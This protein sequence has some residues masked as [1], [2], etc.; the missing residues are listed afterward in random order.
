MFAKLQGLT[1]NLPPMPAAPAVPNL[2]I[3]N[4]LRNSVQ[5]GRSVLLPLSLARALLL[6]ASP[7][8]SRTGQTRTNAAILLILDFF[9]FLI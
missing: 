4:T 9:F 2:N 8:C 7:S 3:T 6:S 1:A 5:A